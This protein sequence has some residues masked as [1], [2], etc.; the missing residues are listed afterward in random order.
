ME[1]YF[2]YIGALLL[3][4]PMCGH[5]FASE[6]VK[7]ELNS[8]KGF[9]PVAISYSYSSGGAE[10]DSSWL[11]MIVPKSLEFPTVLGI[12]ESSAG[13]IDVDE[14]AP[15]EIADLKNLPISYFLVIFIAIGVVFGTVSDLFKSKAKDGA[16]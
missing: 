16:E 1:K 2:K 9:Y 14:I 5:Y 7:N 4:L 15:K 3:L 11:F 6:N 13:E 8:I 10:S 12:N